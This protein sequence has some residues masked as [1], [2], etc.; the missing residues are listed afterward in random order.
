MSG[1][2]EELTTAAAEPTPASRTWRAF[3]R[4][5]LGLV[6]A[7]LL[8]LL[9]LVA[10]AAPLIADY[11]RGYGEDMLVGP[12]AEHWFGTDHLGRDI[13]AQVI[14]GTRTSMAV[15]LGAS[16]LA[17]VLGVAVGVG[18]AYFKRLDG[19]LG[20][21][22]DVMLSLPVLPLMILVAAL[23][24]PSVTTLVVVIALFS[25]PE[26]ARVVRSQALP[27]V[28]LSYVDAAHVMG[29]PNRWVLLRHVLPA[30]SPVIAVSV[31]VTASRAVLSEAGLA[32]L[33][34]GDPSSWSWGT[35][36]YNAQRSGALSSSWWT[37]FFPSLAILLLVVAATL[38]ALAYNDARNPRTR[39]DGAR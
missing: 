25:W 24:G 3:R 34:L 32:F 18:G 6:A 1:L 30:V 5:P 8:A 36:L 17:I 2:S 4:N 29:A 7:G 38:V 26:V 11:P 21:F 9:V 27:I 13:F 16:A 12:S 31:V 39:Q 14:W 15:G 20:L 35:I 23:A 19:V 33:G 37:A 10:L 28:T 22:V